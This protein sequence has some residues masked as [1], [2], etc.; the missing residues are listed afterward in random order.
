[1]FFLQDPPSKGITTRLVFQTVYEEVLNTLSVEGYDPSRNQIAAIG[2]YALKAIHEDAEWTNQPEAQNSTERL[3]LIMMTMLCERLGPAEQR[4]FPRL[5]R[6]TR[7]RIVIHKEL[8]GFI[9]CVDSGRVY[10]SY[11]QG[12]LQQKG[13]Q[14]FKRMEDGLVSES[15]WIMWKIL[16]SPIPGRDFAVRR[17]PHITEEGLSG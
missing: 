8:E 4:R 9:P 1:V 13:E 10:S 6:L 3:V 16:T 15:I 11:A 12:E 7:K 14:E 5:P 17:L 2:F